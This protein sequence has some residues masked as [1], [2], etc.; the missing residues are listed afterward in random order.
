[1]V[2]YKLTKPELIKK[3]YARGMNQF[4]PFA[5]TIVAILLT[6]L[7][8]GIL[9]GIAVGFYFVLKSN[10][11][12]SIVLVNEETLYLVKFYK[13]VSFLQKTTLQKI[14]SSI[15]EGSSVVLDGSNGVFVDDDIQDLIEEFIK[16]GAN[17]GIK[18]ELKKSSLALCPLFKG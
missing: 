12:K 2:G 4:I 10:I 11:H 13:D 9:I 18:I 17:S 7:L 15:P 6:N 14:F 5:V 1:L 16:R 3:M 8:T